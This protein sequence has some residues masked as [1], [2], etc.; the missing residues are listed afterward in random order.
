M[1]E[2][3][4]A[5]WFRVL[6]CRSVGELKAGGRS[7]FIGMGSAPFFVEGPT[8]RSEMLSESTWDGKVPQRVTENTCS[9]PCFRTSV[10]G[11]AQ[12]CPLMVEEGHAQKSN[13][14]PKSLNRTVKKQRERAKKKGKE[15][16]K[17]RRKETQKEIKE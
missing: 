8:E 16:K 5:L 3:V 17:D 4:P 9:R 12:S 14:S 6:S 1:S 10:L 2:R 11:A 15:I 13:T 7:F